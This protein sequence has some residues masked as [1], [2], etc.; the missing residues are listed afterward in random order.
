MLPLPSTGNPDPPQGTTAETYD[1]SDSLIELSPS[2]SLSGHFEPPSWLSDSNDDLDLGSAGAELLPGGLLF[3]A[4][5]NGT[6]YLIDEETLAQG[7][8][9]VYSHQVCSG[10]GSFGGDAYAAGVIYIPCTDGVQALAYHKASRTFTPLWQGPSDAFG[11]P[12]VSGGLIWVVATGGFQ[13]GGTRLYGLAPSTGA[14]R[15][16]E[17]LPSPVVDHFASPSAGGGR[18]FV[19][20]GSSVTAYQIAQLAPAPP[21]VT[22]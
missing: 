12:I 9:A 14:A 17:T 5:K 6:G 2:L 16:T 8:P 1:Y 21:T 13:G 11:P 7:A 15:Y 3:Q 18:L 4:G 22:G 10:H 20:T 19:A